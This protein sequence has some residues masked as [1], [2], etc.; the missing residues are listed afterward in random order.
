M[1]TDK[2]LS[3]TLCFYS[4]DF[5]FFFDMST[6]EEGGRIQSSDLRF[7]RHGPSQLSYLLGTQLMLFTIQNTQ[8]IELTHKFK[9]ANL[10]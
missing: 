10:G 7:M 2:A 8:F 4:I 6:Q 9:S 5:F 1:S 3:A